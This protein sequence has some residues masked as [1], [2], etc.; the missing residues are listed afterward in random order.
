MSIRRDA[1]E[2]VWPTLE[3]RQV[4]FSYRPYRLAVSYG[5]MGQVDESGKLANHA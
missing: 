2:V 5:N 1:S 3:F 4:Y